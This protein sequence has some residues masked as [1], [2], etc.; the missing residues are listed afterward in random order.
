MVGKREDLWE[1]KACNGAGGGELQT[2]LA[3]EEASKVE[4]GL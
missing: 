4:P 2:G 1:G 3:I